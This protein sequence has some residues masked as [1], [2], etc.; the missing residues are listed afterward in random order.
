MAL[1]VCGE[2]CALQILG[3]VLA[4]GKAGG[5]QSASQ[6][7]RGATCAFFFDINLF[8]SKFGDLE[9]LWR[10]RSTSRCPCL[11]ASCWQH[12]LERGGKVK[13]GAGDL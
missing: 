1:Q 4:P 6:S 13:E 3:N 12:I 10:E 9:E 2:P 11:T 7:S 8:Q 5:G